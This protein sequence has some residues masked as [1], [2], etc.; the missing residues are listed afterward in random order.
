MDNT[1]TL[2]MRREDRREDLLNHLKS[3]GPFKLNIKALSQKYGVSSGVVQ[4][5][6]SILVN[7]HLITDI[8]KIRVGQQWCYEKAITKLMIQLESDDPRVVI[9]ASRALAEVLKNYT[10]MLEA[11]GVKDVLSMPMK[12]ELV[13]EN[14]AVQNNQTITLSLGD[15][16][17]RVRKR[18]EEMQVKA[19]VEASQVLADGR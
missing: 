4:R 15:I 6:I 2:Q 7:E 9:A 11:F 8:R 16:E 14:I 10:L 5:E 1:R 18:T 19:D 17:E 13:G 12:I 3:F